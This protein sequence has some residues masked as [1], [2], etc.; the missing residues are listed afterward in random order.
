ME[1][2]IT[3]YEEEYIEY[4]AAN[5]RMAHEKGFA[6]Y[7]EYQMDRDLQDTYKLYEGYDLYKDIDTIAE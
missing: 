2:D 1:N 6:N 5:E 3:N 4:Q 7:E